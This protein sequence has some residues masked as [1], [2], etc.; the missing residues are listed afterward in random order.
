[1]LP[2]YEHSEERVLEEMLAVSA[3]PILMK[4]FN[5]GKYTGQTVKEVADKDAD[6]LAWLFNQK[7]MT[8]EQGGEDDENWIYTLDHYLSNSLKSQR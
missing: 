7:V 6:Y 2:L 4:K 8:R 5:F 1:M 3:R